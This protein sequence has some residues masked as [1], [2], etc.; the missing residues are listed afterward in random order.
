MSVHPSTCMAQLNLDWT[1]FSQNFILGTFT[2]ICPELGLIYWALHMRTYILSRLLW[3]LNNIW[4]RVNFLKIYFLSIT[5]S[6]WGH[7][8]TADLFCYVCADIVSPKKVKYQNI[9]RTKLC[10][11]NVAYFGIP[12]SDQ[13]KSGAPYVQC[14][15]YRLAWQGWLHGIRKCMRPTIP[16]I[17]RKPSTMMIATSS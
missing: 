1:D 7:Q 8:L 10:I 4:R 11:A 9:T 17:W 5:S 13:N 3:L 15:S 12:V 16:Q 2:K 14:G 6:S